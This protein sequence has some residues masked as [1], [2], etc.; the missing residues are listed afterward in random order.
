MNVPA[1]VNDLPGARGGRK[2]LVDTPAGLSVGPELSTQRQRLSTADVASSRH[3]C[4][5]ARRFERATRSGTSR[6]RDAPGYRLPRR[7]VQMP[8]ESGRQLRAPRSNQASKTSEES[9][10]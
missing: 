6:V 1:T 5:S 3:R 9:E 10:D 8:D 2:L 7:L 4:R